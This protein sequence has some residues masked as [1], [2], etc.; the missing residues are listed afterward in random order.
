M[1]RIG[2][3]LGFLA[4]VALAL[5]RV[6]ERRPAVPAAPGSAP[7][8]S[9]APPEAAAAWVDPV[10]GACPTSHPVKA[11]LSSKI[12]HRPGMANYERTHLDRCYAGAAAAEADGLR[13][14]KR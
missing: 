14:A 11:K 10:A 2:L 8:P 9:P 5:V 7:A 6:L 12:F 3:W 1:V 13:P 4:G